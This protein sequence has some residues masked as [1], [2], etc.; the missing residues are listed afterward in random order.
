[1]NRLL[2]LFLLMT[3]ILLFSCQKSDKTNNKKLKSKQKNQTKIE[4][5]IIKDSLGRKVSIPLKIKRIA[6]LYSFTG[7]VVTMLGQGDKIVA[8]I[9]GLKRDKVLLKICPAIKKAVVPKVNGALNIEELV[10]AKPDIVFVRESMFRNQ[11]EKELFDKF[12][13]PLIVIEYSSIKEQQQAIKIIGEA[14]GANERARTFNKYYEECLLKTA[15]ITNKIPLN[16]RVKVYH[17]VNEP[18]KTD[19]AGTLQADWLNLAGAINVSTAQKSKKEHNDLFVNIEQ[20]LLWNPEVIITNESRAKDFILKDTQWANIKAVKNK[21]VYQ[22][23]NGISRWGHPGSLETP[24]ALLWTLKTLYPEY[25]QKINLKRETLIFYKKFFNFSLSNQMLDKIL[26][27]KGM[28]T[29][30]G[31]KIK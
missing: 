24:L 12:N 26:Q 15:T 30:K 17:S 5:Q 6:C 10:K 23:P 11:A 18:F 9:S 7:H 8:C 2:N 27:G 21:K 20:I 28:R 29:R 3:L 19:S 31:K 4:S 22:M 14:I 1:M 13:L 25:S 16:K